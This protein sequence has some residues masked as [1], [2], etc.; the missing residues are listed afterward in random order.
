MADEKFTDFLSFTAWRPVPDFQDVSLYWP[1]LK[2]FEAR[3]EVE[4]KRQGGTGQVGLMELTTSTVVVEQDIPQ[5]SGR[6]TLSLAPGVGRKTYRLVIRKTGISSVQL[7][8]QGTLAIAQPPSEVV[9]AWQFGG[10]QTA[11][12]ATTQ[13][14]LW[15]PA[16]GAHELEF[17]WREAKDRVVMVVADVTVFGTNEAGSGLVR[18]VDAETGKV[19]VELESVGVRVHGM[20]WRSPEPPRV[21]QTVHAMLPTDTGV[22]RYRVE[23]GG[24]RAA[25]NVAA[26]VRIELRR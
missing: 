22:R 2:G 9:R 3:A 5:F 19:V 13:E 17:D 21:N 10:S 7:W 4:T 12:F 6:V 24:S 8:A 1:D 16:P 25:I 18:V 11:F 14:A 20:G 23:V 26:V 15:G